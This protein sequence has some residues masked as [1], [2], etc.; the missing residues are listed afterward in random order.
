MRMKST[1]ISIQ[2]L[3]RLVERAGTEPLS[4]EAQRKLLAMVETLKTVTEK[5]EA[6]D[7]TIEQARALFCDGADDEGLSP[8]A[9]DNRD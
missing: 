2:E 8:S 4:G 1:D 5:L 3:K 9:A 6:G 7:L